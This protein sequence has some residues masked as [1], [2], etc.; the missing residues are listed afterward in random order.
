MNQRLA[1]VESEFPLQIT[2]AEEDLLR[3]LLVSRRERTQ[4]MLGASRLFLPEV[5]RALEAEEV[6]GELRFL[7]LA[8]SA[9]DPDFQG[10]GRAGLWG[11]DAPTARLYGLQVN[12]QVD[13]R[14]HPKLSSRAAARRLKDLHEAF[15]D[16]RLA[17]AAHGAGPAVVRSAMIKAGPQAGYEQMRVHLPVQARGLVS[18]FVAGVYLSMF[19]KD[20]EL[21]PARV[22]LPDSMVWIDLETAL[23]LDRLSAPLGVSS[24]LLKAWNPHFL[25]GLAA[26]EGED[27]LWLDAALQES[28]EKALPGLTALAPLEQER[29]VVATATVSQALA[30]DDLETTSLYVVRRGDNLGRI[31]SRYDVTVSQLRSWNG[32]RG[33]LIYPGQELVLHAPPPPSRPGG[34]YYTVRRGDTL[35]AISRRTGVSVGRLEGLNP[36]VHPR[37]LRPGMRLRLQ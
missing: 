7:P 2:S 16:W 24:D 37:S 26:A 20:E 25:N 21:I 28:F 9:W 22:Q 34:E 12:E 1:R 30:Y 18:A 11:F 32:L 27:D 8:A 6:P 33:D 17:L 23:D 4:W 10:G 3:V 31:A 14:R 15:A 5:E 29:Q 35:W 13:Q 19:H 36:E